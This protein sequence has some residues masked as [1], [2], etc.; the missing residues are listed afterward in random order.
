M[1]APS[2]SVFAVSRGTGASQTEHLG[3]WVE[4]DLDGNSDGIRKSASCTAT[5]LSGLWQEIAKI[6]YS[7]TPRANLVEHT[8]LSVSIHKHD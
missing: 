7:I 6:H 5:P 3:E 4:R 2:S 8:E 1:A